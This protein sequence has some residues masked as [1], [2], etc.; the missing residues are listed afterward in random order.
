M[1]VD[2]VQ[3]EPVSTFKFPAIGEPIQCF[4]IEFPMQRNREFSNAYQGKFFNQ[5]GIWEFGNFHLRYF[6]SEY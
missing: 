6:D 2:A 5:Q 4:A 3:I 1:V